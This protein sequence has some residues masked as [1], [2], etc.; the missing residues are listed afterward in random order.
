V[1]LSDLN[2]E[3]LKK[4][5]IE[6]PK[7]RSKYGAKRT[8]YGGREYASRL[9]ANCAAQLDRL[10]AAG[11]V[12]EWEPQVRFDLGSG[13]KYTA[14][15]VVHYAKGQPRTIDSKGL[16][17]PD[18]KVRRKLFEERYGPL[19]VVKDYRDLPTEGRP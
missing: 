7:T 15:F 6:V 18:F 14:D 9:E 2:P 17:T 11:L 10:K 5:G 8:E 3:Y 16:E 13:L 4:H 19:D 1:K 12:T